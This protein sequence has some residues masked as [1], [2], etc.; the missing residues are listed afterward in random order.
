MNLS[1]SAVGKGVLTPLPTVDEVRF[2]SKTNGEGVESAKH[3]NKEK[4]DTN[5]DLSE[6]AH[7]H[8]PS[9]HYEITSSGL[10]WTASATFA[11]VCADIMVF[12]FIFGWSVVCCFDFAI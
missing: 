2:S 5:H 9:P 12:L 7:Q 10:R 1:S 6:Y 4:S 3:Y 8:K 11:A